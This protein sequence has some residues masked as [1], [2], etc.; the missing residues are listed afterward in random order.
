MAP[1]TW[2]L[3]RSAKARM[4]SQGGATLNL[5]TGGFRLALYTTAASASITNTTGLSLYSQLGTTNECATSGG[6]TAKGKLLGNTDWTLSATGYKFTYT[7]SGIVFT[8][9]ITNV[10]YA[11]IFQSASAGGG[12]VVCY[13]ALSGT[14]FTV[15]TGNTLTVKPAS[16]GVFNLV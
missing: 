13:A 8:G 6:Y 7:T 16:G 15:A 1:G 12:P 3:Y 14:Q 2:T 9:T 5:D 11:L 4:G 10:R